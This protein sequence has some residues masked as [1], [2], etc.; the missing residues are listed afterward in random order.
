MMMF[1]LYLVNMLNV[2]SVNY[3]K[4]QST[5]SSS[6]TKFALTPQ[7]CVLSWKATHTHVF[8]CFD[9]MVGRNPRRHTH[10]QSTV[11]ITL[12]TNV[13]SEAETTYLSEVSELNPGV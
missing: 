5:I 7:C 9:P 13:T 6:Q 12:H 3:L 2:H 8:I 4:Q 11:T 1:V 10:E